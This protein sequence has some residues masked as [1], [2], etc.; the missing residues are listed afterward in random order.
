MF[1]SRETDFPLLL[2]ISTVPVVFVSRMTDA[3]SAARA[4]EAR[5]VRR[6]RARARAK[7]C[8]FVM[9]CASFRSCSRQNFTVIIAESRAEGNRNIRGKGA[10]SV[11]DKTRLARPAALWY[12]H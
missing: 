9:A 6:T 4:G 11:P 7:R 1:F 3:V 5:L 2:E 12:T 8:F 10:A